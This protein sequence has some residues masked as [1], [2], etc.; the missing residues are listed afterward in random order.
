[1]FGGSFLN[2]SIAFETYL[3]LGQRDDV[4]CKVFGVDILF[5][6]MPSLFSSGLLLNRP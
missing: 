5:I 6:S 2:V 4:P 3:N 1:V